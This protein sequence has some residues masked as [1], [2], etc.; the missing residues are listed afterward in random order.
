MLK[1]LFNSLVTKDH[2]QKLV[3]N[4]S[5]LTVCVFHK[6]LHTFFVIIE[7]LLRLGRLMSFFKCVL[8]SKL[9]GFIMLV[10]F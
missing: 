9:N 4:L 7:E 10:F 8:D 6:V 3:R 1:C 2:S 5:D